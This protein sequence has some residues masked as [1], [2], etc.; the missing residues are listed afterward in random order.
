MDSMKSGLFGFPGSL[1]KEGFARGVYFGRG[2]GDKKPLKRGAKR[3][4]QYTT[5]VPI[6]ILRLSAED[7]DDLWIASVRAG[8]VECVLQGC[9]QSFLAEIFPWGE[10]SLLPGQTIFITVENR[11]KKSQIFDG[12]MMVQE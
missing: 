7:S 1:P 8:G 9:P 6:R 4:F 10:L 11:G 3:T 5:P 12:R 2:A